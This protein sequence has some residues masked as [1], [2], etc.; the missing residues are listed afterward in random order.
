M[1]QWKQ[2]N[3]CNDYMISSYGRMKSLKHGRE[4]IL[5][6]RYTQDG[7]IQYS[8]SINGKPKTIRAARA[9]AEYFIPNPDNKPTVN[10]ID[11]NKQNNHVENLEWATLSEQ[12]NHAYAN[13]LKKPTQGYLQGNAV[14]TE[15]EVKEIR[16]IYK[17]RDSEFGM[18]ALADKY[19]VSS[20]V[21]NR[22][23]HY[24]SYKNVK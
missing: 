14:L 23:V 13:D 4:K 9:V 2:L 22:V 6:Y 17:A 8:V 18:L 12:M 11:G 16:R 21:I 20:S 3:E 19:G 7:Y 24:R 10:H 5:S 1:E 15:S